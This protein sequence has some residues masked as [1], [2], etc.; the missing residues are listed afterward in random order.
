MRGGLRWVHGLMRDA[1]GRGSVW[2][3]ERRVE[4]GNEVIRVVASGGGEIHGDEVGGFR[5]MEGLKDRGS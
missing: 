5:R 3:G 4:G 2:D 1:R